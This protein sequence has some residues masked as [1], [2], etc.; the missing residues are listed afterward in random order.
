[1]RG[2][3]TAVGSAAPDSSA[4]AQGRSD[5]VLEGDA[6]PLSTTF[7]AGGQL[8]PSG[9]APTVVGAQRAEGG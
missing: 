7:T 1:M 4:A 3:R 2:G 5:I 6:P 8:P 9:A